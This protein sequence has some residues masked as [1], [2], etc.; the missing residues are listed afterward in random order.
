MGNK[1]HLR[2]RCAGREW[3][4]CKNQHKESQNQTVF[5]AGRNLEVMQSLSFQSKK[6][7]G[8][9]GS[10]LSL[11]TTAGFGFI[12]I[13]IN[14]GRKPAL[15]KW[16]PGKWSQVKPVLADPGINH[17][18]FQDRSWCWDGNQETK[19]L[20]LTIVFTVW[21]DKLLSFSRAVSH[22]Q[23]R[24]IIPLWPTLQ[25]CCEDWDVN[26]PQTCA[27]TDSQVNICWYQMSIF[28][29]NLLHFW[30]KSLE[31]QY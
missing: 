31:I 6:A 8:K 23:L 4:Q 13:F 15:S 28:S 18:H 17:R 20:S 7:P 29:F 9:N 25:G 12:S 22:A 19:A 26:K 14:A 16:C 27:W 1:V 24:R 11:P 21:L 10:L 2:H 30:S 5:W 3:E